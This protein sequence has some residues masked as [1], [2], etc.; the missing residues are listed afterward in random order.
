M[1]APIKIIDIIHHKNKYSTQVFHILNRMPEFLYE[2][3]GSWLVGEDQGFF[4][5]Y[6]HKTPSKAFR[7]FAGREF[8]IPLVNGGGRPRS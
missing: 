7:A 4:S 8:E 2:R 6:K 1:K 3:E 5:F